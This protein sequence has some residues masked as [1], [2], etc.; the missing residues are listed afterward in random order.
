NG[1]P[2]ETGLLGRYSLLPLAEVVALY[3]ERSPGS[4]GWEDGLED[5]GVVFETVPF[6]RV[7]RLSR[8]DFWVTVG[9]DRGGDYIAVD[10]DPAERGQRGQVIEYGRNIYGPLDYVS[11]SVL[12]MLTEVVEALRAGHHEV[13]D[14]RYL[15]AEVPRDEP[16][17]YEEVLDGPG[18]DLDEPELVQRVYLNDYADVDL[19]VFEPLT[20]LRALSVNS[21]TTVTPSIGG[22]K[23]L[24]SLE[25]AADSVDLAA[26]AGH[27]TLWYV[28]LA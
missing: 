4:Y 23:A 27:P 11:P 16:P 26:L 5:D 12:T 24:E 28:Q 2:A 22:L 8:N 14:D 1:D 17:S 3:L 20:S 9:S 15:R 7:K 21:A 13:R 18:T 6:G 25:I 19:A 10:L